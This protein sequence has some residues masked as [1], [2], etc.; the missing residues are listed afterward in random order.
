[1]VTALFGHREGSADL[2][3]GQVQSLITS[4][5]PSCVLGTGQDVGDGNH[6]PRGPRAEQTRGGKT[7]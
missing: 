1:M 4:F 3:G 7:E 5:C 2:G 6:R